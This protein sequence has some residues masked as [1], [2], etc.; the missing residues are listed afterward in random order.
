MARA[1]PD[2]GAVTPVVPDERGE[3]TGEPGPVA[4][5]GSGEFLDV[6]VPVDAALLAGRP[7]RAVVIP[8]ASAL[9]GDERVAYWLDLGRR[10]Y[11]AMDVEVVPLDVRTRQDADDPALGAA[12]AGAG[13]VYLSGGNPAHL[14]ATLRDTALWAAVERAW[15]E[16]TALG[17]CSA[18]AMALSAGAPAELFAARDDP[19]APASPGRAAAGG[20]LGVVPGVAVIPHFDQMERWR[21]GAVDWFQAW[22]PLGTVLVGIDERTALVQAQGRWHVE[23]LGSVWVITGEGRTPHGPGSTVPLPAAPA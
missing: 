20:G 15:R 10:H 22:Q 11:E 9:E 3:V 12:V 2:R 1:G 7:R 18:G 16:G 19:A 14:S 21:P 17:G 13:L 8:T 5:V 4:L 6:M 23:G